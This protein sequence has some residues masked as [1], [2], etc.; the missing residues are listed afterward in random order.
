MS[1]VCSVDRTADMSPRMK[2][3]RGDKAGAAVE[4]RRFLKL[5]KDCDL[6]LKPL[7][8]SASAALR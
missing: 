1:V 3:R 6:E 5:W 2:L 8:D 4:F 7:T